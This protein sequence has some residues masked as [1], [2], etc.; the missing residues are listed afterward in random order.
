MRYLLV[1]S[2]AFALV[3]LQAC[4][5]KH[6]EQP[7]CGFVQNVYGER[8]SWKSS[9]PVQLYV[10]N[11]FPAEMLPALDSAI[12]KWTDAAGR[13]L[14][15]V[16]SYNMSGNPSP[17]QDG[18][19]VIYWLSSWEANKS[20][21]QGRTS[22]YWVG[23]VIREADV[24]INAK[25]FNYYLTTPRM[26]DDVHL[27]SLLVHELGHVLGLKH[28]DEGGSVMGTY[29][30]SQ[31]NRSTVVGIDREALACEYM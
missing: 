28:R 10:H 17:S 3:G 2:L 15:R 4:A 13:P 8:I 26:Y 23:D 12:R 11:S 16:V 5:P 19:N 14:F 29:L 30:F 9:V 31:T 21:E 22:V 18:I 20:K 1:L 6:K 24:R 25:D 27:E 7:D